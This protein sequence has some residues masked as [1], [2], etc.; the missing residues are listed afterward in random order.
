MEFVILT[1]WWFLVIETVEWHPGTLHEPQTYYHVGPFY[2][3]TACN[4]ELEVLH[5]W[6]DKKSIFLVTDCHSHNEEGIK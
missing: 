2:E 1:L 4:K 3:I 6:F 5:D